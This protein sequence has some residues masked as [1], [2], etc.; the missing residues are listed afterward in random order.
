MQ[1]A[2]F[3]FVQGLQKD[4]T[5]TSSFCWL[6]ML[7]FCLVSQL[8]GP[9]LL[10][11]CVAVSI[12][13]FSCCMVFFSRCLRGNV[14]NSFIFTQELC[15]S[16]I[17][18]QLIIFILAFFSFLFKFRF[19]TDLNCLRS[20][21]FDVDLKEILICSI[22][23]TIKVHHLRFISQLLTLHQRDVSLK[24][25]WATGSLE[26]SPLQFPW[27]YFLWQKCNEKYCLCVFICK[28]GINNVS[29]MHFDLLRFTYI[30]VMHNP[31]GASSLQDPWK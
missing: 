3:V 19:H 29:V 27:L 23:W 14:C 7:L 5:E 26:L 16:A 6:P 2:Y 31:A 15:W 28:A 8:F 25:G 12:E 20:C 10:Q 1:A 9:Q 30:E 22:C 21:I 17:C 4:W 11:F 24:H 13:I 18:E